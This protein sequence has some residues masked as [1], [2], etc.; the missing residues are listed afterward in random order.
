[1]SVENAL[2]EVIIT[3]RKSCRKDRLAVIR[4]LGIGVFDQGRCLYINRA[5]GE[6]IVTDD[7]F[8]TRETQGPID[9]FI[10]D[11][12][13]T[14]WASRRAF[15]SAGQTELELVG[16]IYSH[17]LPEVGYDY[18]VEF[19]REGPIQ[20]WRVDGAGKAT[21][22]ALPEDE[23]TFHGQTGT[24]F[25]LRAGWRALLSKFE[26]APRLTLEEVEPGYY[27]GIR[28]GMPGDDDPA[29]R[30]DPELE[31]AF[32]QHVDYR[33]DTLEFLGS[34]EAQSYP[35]ESERF[36]E[37]TGA[38]HEAI[39]TGARDAFILASSER[40]IESVEDLIEARSLE[41]TLQV[42]HD[43]LKA[44]IERTP[45]S[46]EVDL[47]TL[48]LRTLHTGR[49]FA[50]GLTAFL[51]PTLDLLDDAFEV[52]TV[53]TS[54]LP[55]HSITIEN[56]SLMVIQR[57][58][59]APSRWELMTMAGRSR[60]HGAARTEGIL[61][62]L[63]FD[64]STGE[65]LETPFQLGV[66]PISGAPA[67]VEKLIRPTSALG[68]DPRTL[69]GVP[70]G[71]HMV[72]YTSESDQHSVPLQPQPNLTI[73]DCEAAYREGLPEATTAVLHWQKME[74]ESNATLAIGFNIGSLV[75]EPGRL[76]T[77]VE[78]LDLDSAGQWSVIGLLPDAILFASND[79]QPAVIH[80][81]R[82]RAV[83]VAENL[84]PGRTWS[85][86]VMRKMTFEDDAI[87]RVEQPA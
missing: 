17:F 8:D 43:E 47:G 40:F 9:E 73:S 48:F 14:W 11:L 81:A 57:P 69:I 85:L 78:W 55:N 23:L 56:G 52:W 37:W 10:G 35:F 24:F 50:R 4:R 16:G 29:S 44:T 53:A 6:H 72:Y 27:L 65:R 68:V 76:R 26:T 13:D 32:S 42:S 30:P 33:F 45:L 54:N 58:G 49:S 5:T 34:P 36:P 41:I 3:F 20:S 7:T 75:L 64:P 67:R 77:L 15:E 19:R 74:A 39:T 38:H 18:T 84:Y 61:R 86:D 71:H 21:K 82:R 70:V 12:V 28:K 66:C 22:L 63:G 83:E 80:R 59:E 51:S 87:G 46:I 62:L 1:M 31:F 25:D 60:T 79:L 2:D